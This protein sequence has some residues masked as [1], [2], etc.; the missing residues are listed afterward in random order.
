MAPELHQYAVFYILGAQD[1]A[2]W[3]F[4]GIWTG[5]DQLDAIE[6]SHVSK[7][8]GEA[9]SVATVLWGL[10]HVFTRTSWEEE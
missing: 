9:T 2:A 5:A 7:A 3:Q 10:A 8:H 1:F 6:R 4:F